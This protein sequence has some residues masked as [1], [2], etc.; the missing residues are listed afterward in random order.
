MVSVV[1]R[2]VAHWETGH[3]FCQA[4]ITSSI[5]HLGPRMTSRRRITRKTNKSRTLHNKHT[6]FIVSEPLE[7][8]TVFS[9]QLLSLT[10]PQ[11]DVVVNI[12]AAAAANKSCAKYGGRVYFGT[13]PNICDLGDTA[14]PD[15]SVKA[16]GRY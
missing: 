2:T 14:G 3:E 5:L 1:T 7:T 11:S 8:V 12:A 13:G 4:F 16:V 9:T 6:W 10:L 15:L